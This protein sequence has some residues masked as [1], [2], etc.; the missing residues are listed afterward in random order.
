MARVRFASENLP[1][2]AQFENN[3]FTEMWSGSEEGSY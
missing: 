1:T 3:Y 2:G